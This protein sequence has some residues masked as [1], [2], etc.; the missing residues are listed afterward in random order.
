MI[1]KRKIQALVNRIAE[2]FHP[3]KVILFGSY[4][5]G[6][7]T[8]DSDVDLLVIMQYSGRRLDLLQKIRKSLQDIPFPKDIVV[9]SPE[10]VEKYGRYIGTLLYPALKEGQ[11]LYEKD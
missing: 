1:P 8:P 7:P 5:R 3:D 2:Q 4:A 9:R 11:V 10:E 6:T